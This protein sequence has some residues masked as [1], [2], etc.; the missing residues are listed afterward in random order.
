MAHDLE[1]VILRPPAIPLDQGQPQASTSSPAERIVVVLTMGGMYGVGFWAFV[2]TGSLFVLLTGLVSP[3]LVSLSTHVYWQLSSDV[4][5]GLADRLSRSVVRWVSPAS[6]AVAVAAPDAP[7]SAGPAA[8]QA[9]TSAVGRR[10]VLSQNVSS[11]LRR[12][13][14]GEQGTITAAPG[15]NSRR[16]WTVRL[17]RG[18]ELR[19]VPASRLIPI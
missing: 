10:V 17:D 1:S 11:R 12:G 14:R 7:V 9:P 13:Y 18:V 2:Q 15:T 3:L 4:I 6:P 8:N 19:G 16:G 5:P